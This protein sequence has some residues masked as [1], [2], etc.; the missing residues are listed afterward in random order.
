MWLTKLLDDSTQPQKEES[1]EIKD[2]GDVSRDAK[3][4][5]RNLRRLVAAFGMLKEKMNTYSQESPQ[6]ER[7]LR[8]DG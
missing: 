5:V 2:S 7:E 1:E 8:L 3:V 4:D 6:G